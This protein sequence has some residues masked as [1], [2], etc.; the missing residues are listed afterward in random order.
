MPANNP[1]II[2]VD[3]QGSLHHIT[4]AALDMMERR[5]RLIE[6]YTGDDAM[7][8]LKISS[9]DLLITAHTLVD[10]TNG[11]LLAM[12]AKRELA[13]LPIIVVG[14]EGDPEMD[15]E[16]LA[17]SPFQYL[18]RP[19]APEAFIRALRIALDGPQAAPRETTEEDIVPVP[20]IAADRLKP[21]MRELMREVGSMAI[22]LADRNGKV[23]SYDGAAG[24]VDR[25]LLA[26]ALAPGFGS[27]GKILSVLG[28]QPRLLKYYNGNKS[29]LFCLALG[30]HYFLILIYD[31]Q[32]PNTA[33]GNVKRY[34]NAAVG[35]MLEIV[36]EVAYTVKPSLSHT[37]QM[38]KVAENA[39]TAK[40]KTKTQ[41]T[42]IA[43]A[44]PLPATTAP[45]AAPTVIANFDPS[46]F[47]QDID[48]LYQSQADE[49]FNPERIAQAAAN[50]NGERI[51]F[52]DALEQGI[53]DISEE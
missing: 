20:L 52:S 15:D 18:R 17:Q 8:E 9:P 42:L 47:D 12:M 46:L 3:T 34:G 49:L 35:K 40:R 41:E 21:I 25:D 38:P 16:T 37:Q 19:F 26:A 44:A 10:T 11:P 5:P 6:T 29:D 33:L 23:I 24:Y 27:T 53:I 7:A 39:P 13:A 14:T 31:G 45:A 36:G 51:T 2:V 1:R 43:R 4:R 32:A 28:D 48:S 22:V 30:L 50:A